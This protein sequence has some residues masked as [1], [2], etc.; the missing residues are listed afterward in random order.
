MM[1]D[2]SKDGSNKTSISIYDVNEHVQK[3]I[4]TAKQNY[5]END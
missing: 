4:K 2:A 5:K 1:P 3:M